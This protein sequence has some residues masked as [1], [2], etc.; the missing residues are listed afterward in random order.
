VSASWLRWVGLSGLL[1]MPAASAQGQQGPLSPPAQAEPFPV[2]PG[3]TAPVETPE[4]APEGPL[5]RRWRWALGLEGRALTD[6]TSLDAVAGLSGAYYLTPLRDWERYPLGLLTFI[7]HPDTVTAS[8]GSTPGGFAQ[9]AG[10]ILYP[11]ETVGFEADLSVEEDPGQGGATG[12]VLAVMQQYFRHNLRG[13]LGYS[14]SR[15]WEPTLYEAQDGIH[16]TLSWLWGSLLLSLELDGT[17]IEQDFQ[18]VTA[19]SL[20]RGAT[21]SAALYVGR[22]WSVSVFGGGTLLTFSELLGAQGETHPGGSTSQ[23]SFG[24]SGE[25]YL[26]ESLYVI[27]TAG[28]TFHQFHLP[29][30]LMIDPKTPFTDTAAIVPA[31][32]LSLTYRL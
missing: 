1:L 20:S 22:R 14:G 8:A 4:A 29:E 6:G 21:L 5:V 24:L 17:I 18:T 19:Y 15:T 12:R 23:E 32:S 31:I 7:E 11:W 13:Q 16:A 2:G 30:G 27:A 25:V 9:G 10:L 26:T 28:P 3:P